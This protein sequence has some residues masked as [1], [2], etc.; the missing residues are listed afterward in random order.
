[1]PAVAYFRTYSYTPKPGFE[2]FEGRDECHWCKIRVLS[3]W[4][5]QPGQVAQ[6]PRARDRIAAR[7]NCLAHSVFPVISLCPSLFWANSFPVIRIRQKCFLCPS[8][9]RNSYLRPVFSRRQ[10]AVSLYFSLL[11]REKF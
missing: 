9:L 2:G 6:T 4:P 1:M 5:S 10:A 8:M 3:M 7:L 11:A